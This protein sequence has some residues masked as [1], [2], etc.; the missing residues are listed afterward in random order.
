MNMSAPMTKPPISALSIEHYE[1]LRKSGLSDK[2]IS[3]S[4]IK[5]ISHEYRIVAEIEE[6]LGFRPPCSQNVKSAYSIPYPGTEHIRLK[7][8]Y[9][10]DEGKK[11]PKYL[12]KRGVSNRLYIPDSI[13]EVLQDAS[14]PIYF[15]EGEKKAL[16]ACQE[17][18][19]CIGISG[20]WNWSNGKKE[21]IPDFDLINFENRTVY[22]VPDNDFKLPARHGYKKNLE[23]AVRQLAIKI[24]KRGA[25]V[26]V[27]E[28]PK[29]GE[30]F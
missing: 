20:L 24:K 15:T 28:L 26:F 22:I 5:S 29:T 25:K 19:P 2:T 7:V 8:F 17:G 12:Q 23:A 13:R 30:S 9:K 18:L 16:K 4:G 14:R 3:E 11:Q 10:I 21:L 1:D 6:L 27:V